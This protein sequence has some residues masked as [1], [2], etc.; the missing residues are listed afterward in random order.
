[1]DDLIEM[2]IDQQMKSARTRS[3]NTAAALAELG[4]ALNMEGRRIFVRTAYSLA[5]AD[6]EVVELEREIILK[7]ARR[8]GFSKNEANE[9]LEALDTES[10]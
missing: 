10:N 1:M 7:T 8:L 6:G 5:C 2:L 3:K 9:L 4:S